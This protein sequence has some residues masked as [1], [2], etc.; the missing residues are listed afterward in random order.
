MLHVALLC[1]LVGQVPPPPVP[2]P[3]ESYKDSDRP[4][5]DPTA[6]RK[7]L[8]D[9]LVADLRSQ[10]K[11]DAQKFREVEAMVNSA[12][13]KQLGQAVQ[14]YQQRKAE[15]LAEAEAN[16]HRLEA[17][18]DRLKVA[19]E[20]RK[21]VYEQEQAMAAYGFALAQQQFQWLLGQFYAAPFYVNPPYYFVP[22]P[23]RSRHW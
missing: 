10:G 5:A 17:Y 18:R 2:H 8:R 4:T 20:R 19:V 23:Y 7:W 1:L 9:H 6:Q 12:T 22:R 21:Q 3:P 13:D 16:L 14:Y 11:G 15:Q